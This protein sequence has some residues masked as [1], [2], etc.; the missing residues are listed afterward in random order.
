MVRNS[1]GANV[2][3]FISIS[4]E[5]GGEGSLE[6]T[7]EVPGGRGGIEQNVLITCHHFLKRAPRWPPSVTSKSKDALDSEL[8]L[9]TRYLKIIRKVDIG[10][11]SLY[12]TFFCLCRGGHFETLDSRTKP[13][14]P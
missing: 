7:L 3:Y 9:T 12:F 10:R 2:V 14:F 8:P 11:K 6:N 5:T 13:H 1:T 4:W